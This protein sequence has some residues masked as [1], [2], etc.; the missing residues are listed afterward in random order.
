MTCIVGLAQDNTVWIGGDSAVTY[1][2]GVMR[3]P[4]GKVF[5]RGEVVLGC[6][7]HLRGAEIVRHAFDPPP[8]PCPDL[9]RYMHTS[10]A[11]TL[12][13]LF[14]E[15]GFLSYNQGQERTETT[16]LV[17]VRGRLYGVSSNFNVYGDTHPWLA[18]GDGAPQALGA[19]Y[20]T[21]CTGLDPE[22]R[23]RLALEAAAC[24]SKTV[25]PPFMV[26]RSPAG[27][28]ACD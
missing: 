12:R 16:L 10:F 9:D 6:A 1:A 18:L 20:A 27:A 15:H 24:Y 19:L 8:I 28:A 23:L 17:G 4:E 26:L 7:G 14:R 3:H 5:T 25:R 21:A 13:R 2:E 11:G 22:A